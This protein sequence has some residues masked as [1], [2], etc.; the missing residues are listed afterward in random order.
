VALQEEMRIFASLGIPA[1]EVWDM[2]T[3]KAGVALRKPEL[4][5]I[6]DGAPADLLLFRRDPTASLDALDSLE[7]V[8]A[9]GRLY[10]IAELRD[11]IRRW[12]EHFDRVV[13]DRLSVTA[14][15]V[16]LKFSVK[17]DY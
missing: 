1:A 14:A 10:R 17:R 12:Q 2:A 9:Q 15:P 13:F 5:V 3:R 8:V 6:R 4:G 11:A 16:L 7:A